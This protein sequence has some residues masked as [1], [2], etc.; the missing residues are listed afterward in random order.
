MAA[1]SGFKTFATGDVL[2]AADTN[3][4]LMQGV[5]VFA[6]AAARTA[7][8]TSPQEGNMSYLKDTNSTEYYSGSAWVAVAG[9]P[10][11]VGC[12]LNRSTIAPV[13]ANNTWT[14]V[15]LNN[16][17]LDTNG[18]HDNSTNPSRIT[19]PT[20]YTGKYDITANAYWDT[21]AGGT[22][23]TRIYKNGALFIDFGN[24]NAASGEYPPMAWN[25]VVSLSAGDYI[26]FY[27]N[28]TSGSTLG[29]YTLATEGANWSVQYL[30]A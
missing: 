23:G 30:G 28:Q 25:A 2:T 13:I 22:R 3:G 4:Y 27:V 20:G 18:F 29:Y 11:F 14:A 16:E 8:V 24:N 15:P 26:E 12:I 1:G 10:S 5:W 9:T 7:A 17:I 21:A 6:D 19:I